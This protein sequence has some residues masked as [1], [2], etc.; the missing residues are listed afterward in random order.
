MHSSV[1]SNQSKTP[2]SA[3]SGPLTHAVIKERGYMLS[4]ALHDFRF[5]KLGVPAVWIGRNGAHGVARKDPRIYS[6]GFAIG[7]VLSR[8]AYGA[9]FRPDWAHKPNGQLTTRARPRNTRLQ[10]SDRNQIKAHRLLRPI[11]SVD[12]VAT[13]AFETI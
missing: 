13:I 7:F 6:P 1:T 4:H 3:I 10:I 11:C 2:N 5:A 12:T 9:C 8:V